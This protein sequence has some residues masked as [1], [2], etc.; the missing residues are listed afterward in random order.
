MEEKAAE[1]WATAT[2]V[3]VNREYTFGSQALAVAFTELKSVGGTAWPNV[4]F[5][6][7]QSDYA[8]AVW[9]NSTLGLLAYWWHSSRQQSSKARMTI[10]SA[11]RLPVLDF[12]ALS[13]EQLAIG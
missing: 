1:V 13:D 12:R 3:H 7:R 6:E 5:A 11:E 9:G 10:R 8:F 2:H 4:S